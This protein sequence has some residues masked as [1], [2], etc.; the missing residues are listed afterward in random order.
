MLKSIDCFCKHPAMGDGHLNKCKE[1]TKSDVREIERQT[2]NV[3]VL[4]I[5]RSNDLKRVVA[6]LEYQ[7]GR[8]EETKKRAKLAYRERY[9]LKAQ[10]HDSVSNAMR[11]GRIK[12]QPCEI[13]GSVAHAHHDDYSKPLEVRWLCIK[14]HVEWHKSNKA[15][16][17][18][19]GR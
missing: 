17:G 5:E 2:S 1:C 9:S 19:D 13:C 6:R 8:R 12:K 18:F 7:I 16:G 11:D 10:A 15:I 3:T 14:H 4:T